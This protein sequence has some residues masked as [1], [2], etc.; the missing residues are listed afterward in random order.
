MNA[1]MLSFNLDEDSNSWANTDRLI[2]MD[3]AAAEKRVLGLMMLNQIPDPA[4]APQTPKYEFRRRISKCTKWYHPHSWTRWQQLT[5]GTHAYLNWTGGRY[6]IMYRSC[7]HCGYTAI[8]KQRLT[9]PLY[10]ELKTPADRLSRPGLRVA[11]ATLLFMPMLLF[12]VIIHLLLAVFT[13]INWAISIIC[14]SKSAGQ[15]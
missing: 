13:P 9:Q 8:R 3:F 15:R 2:S 6:K 4:P 12:S 10:K 11:V 1:Q 14:S 7:R 5:S